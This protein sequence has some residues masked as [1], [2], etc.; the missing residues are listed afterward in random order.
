MN[1]DEVKAFLKQL[2]K[3]FKTKV[4]IPIIIFAVVIIVLVGIA[5]IEMKDEVLKGSGAADKF[6]DSV[7]MDMTNERSCF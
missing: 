2:S 3:A 6:N 5:Y 1:S 7:K 4:L